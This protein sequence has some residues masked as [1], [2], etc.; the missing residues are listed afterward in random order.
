[1]NQF[2]TEFDG[3]RPIAVRIKDACS[4]SGLGLTSIY[5]LLKEGKLEGLTVGRRR[6][7][8]YASLENLLKP[9]ARLLPSSPPTPPIRR[10]PRK[11][12]VAEVPA[13]STLD[14]E[15]PARRPRGRPR[16]AA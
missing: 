5:A 10:E 6:L 11:L 15:T 1:M 13:S 14:G 4:L 7:I 12:P 16:T 3:L 8:T 2:T 9:G